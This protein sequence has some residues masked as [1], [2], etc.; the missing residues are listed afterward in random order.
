ML[1]NVNGKDYKYNLDDLK[2]LRQAIEAHKVEGKKI[3]SH[4]HKMQEY[5]SD[6]ED[7]LIELEYAIQKIEKEQGIPREKIEEPEVV[8][9]MTDFLA[10]VL[11]M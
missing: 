9:D 6:W 3:I 4:F 2:E 8:S 11:D 5:Y 7:R 1:V 10:D